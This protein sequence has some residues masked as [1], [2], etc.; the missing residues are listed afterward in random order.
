MERLLVK[1]FDFSIRITEMIKYLE[2]KEKLFPLCERLLT[3]AT[4]IG[5]G[6]RQAAS[7]GRLSQEINQ[8]TLAYAQEAEYLLELMSKTEY[9]S[10]QQS[11]HILNDC[12]DIMSA[13]RAL[14]KK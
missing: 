9:L 13:I 4:G 14:N 2:E 8:R 11:K 7:A 10:E 5:I 1:S 3:C 6:L 12:R